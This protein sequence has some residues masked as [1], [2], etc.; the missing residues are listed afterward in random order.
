M[1]RVFI[2][3]SSKQA[4]EANRICRFLESHGIPCWMAPRN[5]DPG[6]NYPT[7]IVH[8]IRECSALVLLAS[9]YTNV[10]GHVSNEVSLAFDSHKTII[11]FKLEDVAFSDEFLYYLGRKHWIDAFDDF[12]QGMESLFHTLCNV[13][14]LSPAEL[15]RAARPAPVQ[16][17]AP[18]QPVQPAAPVMPQ[19][20]A[21]ARAPE[22]SRADITAVLLARTKKYSYS[23]L[24]RFEEGED[25]ALFER[26]ADRMFHQTMRVYR[27]GKPYPA[28][29]GCISCLVEG[30]HGLAPN[31][32][33][34]VCG[35]PGSAKNMLLQLAY[36]R[37]A[38][39]FA[40]GR[41]DLLPCYVSVNYFEKSEYDGDVARQ[42]A[43]R[44]R[45][46]MQPFLDYVQA[47]PEVQPV[48]F[49]DAVR[50]HIIA[51][52]AP[53][54]VL[55]EVLRPLGK[56]RRVMA[57]DT[58]LIQ[59]RQHLKKVLP[60]AGAE[61]GWLF[62]TVPLDMADRADVLEF[63]RTVFALYDSA[64]VQPE[65]LYQTM[66]SLKY[67][68][69]DIF[70]VRMVAQ[71][72][73][74]PLFD[75]SISAA[76]MYEKMALRELE[77]DETQ[78]QAAASAI[79]EYVFGTDP[80][81]WQ[82]SYQGRQWA[83]VHKHHT[84]MEFL[85]AYHFADRIRNY[86]PGDDLRFFH[87]LL[88]AGESS[89]L[90]QMLRNS[91]ELQDAL[92]HF[93]MDHYSCFDVFQQCNGA[94]WLGRVTYKSLIIPVLDFLHG[95]F[96]RLRPL[97]KTCNSTEPENLDNHFL[98]RAVCKG[99]LL[100]GQADILDEYLCMI[101]INDAANALNRGAT[102]EYYSGGYQ[103]A[104]NDTY[105][106]DTD[107]LA[108]DAALN[109]LCHKVEASFAP[110]SQHFTESNLVTLTMLLQ[111][112]CQRRSEPHMP[113]LE[114]YIRK[115]IRYIELYKVRP[116][117]ISSNK[118]AFYLE[119][120]LDDFKAYLNTPRFDIS[121]QV[122][123]CFRSIKDVKRGQWLNHD[124]YDPESI[125]EHTFSAWLMAMLFLPEDIGTADYNKREV[126]DMLLIHDLAEAEM[127]DQVMSLNEPS[128]DLKQQNAV[129]RKL[130]VKGTYPQIANL[131][132]YYNIWTGYYNNMN[133]NARVARDINT[134]QTCYTF[135]EYYVRY[136]DHFVPAEVTTWAQYEGQLTTEI[137]FRLWD[138]LIRS[139]ESY[140]PVLEQAG[141]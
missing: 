85:I 137:G 96:H 130:F 45:E 48:V 75:G 139:N 33:I 107:P 22:V 7:Q 42:M 62:Q 105:Y 98:F 103:I 40:A 111:A 109:T 97:V 53:E 46:E 24:S 83:L 110:R 68:R 37:M 59:N 131:T 23:L 114:D 6:S 55:S 61:S 57:M 63:I 124:I 27:H 128:K 1:N 32:G 135:F 43:D 77:G 19:P 60:I 92:Y 119:S 13:L 116:Q 80:D 4:Q 5:I 74:S 2:S 21:P 78:L 12:D 76:E 106:L 112:R 91:F 39:D 25:R 3:H 51:R 9:E 34:T 94:S 141:L 125:S 115:A 113:G 52:V 121:Q 18:P 108:G 86:A 10:S 126:L 88:T 101:I 120:V 89:F 44:I 69:A 95:E 58:G 122:Y 38:D 123:D 99:L 41:S 28:A 47:H 29:G 17:V 73:A 71:E 104:A 136:P 70:L 134:I 54:N 127:G 82:E 79:F 31:A 102:I 65:T 72:L 14:D 87:I 129:L 20:A 64:D 66:L 8:A 11:P 133:I 132:Y 36:F 35:L 93:V 50:Q 56:Y 140:R 30:V 49:A 100:Q 84:Y 118:I 117:H 26:N 67:T 15:T 16:P 90:V 81:A 138:Q